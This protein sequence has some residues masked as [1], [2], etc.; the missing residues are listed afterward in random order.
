MGIYWGILRLSLTNLYVNKL[1]SFLTVLGIIFG[2]AAVMATL[3]SNEGASQYIQ[4]ELRKLGTNVVTVQSRG[5]KINEDHIHLVRKYTSVFSKLTL[6]SYG[7]GSVSLD[8]NRI[9]TMSWRGARRR[10]KLNFG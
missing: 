1:R 4:T 6:I 2:T 5:A 9:E 7:T 10:N 3:T 8:G